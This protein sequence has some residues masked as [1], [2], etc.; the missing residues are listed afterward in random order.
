M[1]LLDTNHC[2]RIIFGETKVI[3]RLQEYQGLGV[4]T[5]VIVRGE[6]LYM[7]EKSYQQETNLRFVVNFLQ[8]IDLYPIVGGVAD[9]YGSLKGDIVE[10]FGP[11]DK[12]KR[13]KF[14]VQDLG[15]SDNDLWIAST[16]LHYNLTVVSADSDFQRIQQVQALALESWL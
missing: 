14:T 6:L 5:S 15:F 2:S 13:R 8:T 9:V 4:A 11:K 3:R 12:A 16:A 10:R 7:A 1:Y